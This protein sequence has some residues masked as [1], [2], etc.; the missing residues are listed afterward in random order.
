MHA[1][2]E[3]V[4]KSGMP[5]PLPIGIESISVVVDR[6]MSPE[7]YTSCSGALRTRHSSSQCTAD[8]LL[9]CGRRKLTDYVAAEVG[10]VVCG[11][12]WGVR[13]CAA[14]NRVDSNFRSG[15]NNTLR[16]AEVGERFNDRV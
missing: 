4:L 11:G 15:N 12:E 13:Q 5:T 6:K 1:R 14:S 8:S 9:E 3:S 10:W 2:V 16:I 7:T